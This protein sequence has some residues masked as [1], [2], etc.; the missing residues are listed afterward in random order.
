MTE[1]NQK[2]RPVYRGNTIEI[3]ATIYDDDGNV[4]DVNGDEILFTLSAGECKDE[5][6]IERTDAHSGVGYHDAENGVISIRL[7]SEDTAALER[8][9]YV[10]HITLFSPNETATVTTGTI[11]MEDGYTND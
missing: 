3:R 9:I 1:T 11:H 2:I 7:S 8:R 4:R 10:Y 6:V 5:P